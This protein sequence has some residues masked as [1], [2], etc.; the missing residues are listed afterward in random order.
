MSVQAPIRSVVDAPPAPRPTGY[1]VLVF[2]RP[3]EEP[4]LDRRFTELDLAMEF[5]GA[6]W[7]DAPGDRPYDVWVRSEATGRLHF[8]PGLRVRLETRAGGDPE[9][10]RCCELLERPPQP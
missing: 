10:A 3:G 2:T 1:A 8:A 4:R 7:Y 6:C 5:A 9:A